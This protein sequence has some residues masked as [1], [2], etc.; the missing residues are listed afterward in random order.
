[1]DK[2]SRVVLPPF[3]I[4]AGEVAQCDIA[5]LA[6]EPVICPQSSMPC[7]DA[8]HRIGGEPA[9]DARELRRS[10]PRALSAL[11]HARS[12]KHAAARAHRGSMRSIPSLG[13]AGWL[14]RRQIGR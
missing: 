12:G 11:R 7:V 1:M 6:I 2:R 5:D 13:S 14:A 10:R 4:G 9:A 8:D 3:Q